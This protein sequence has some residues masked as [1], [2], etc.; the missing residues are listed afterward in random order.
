M[1]IRDSSLLRIIHR[2][3]NLMKS[4][5]KDT[6]LEDFLVDYMKQRAIAMSLIIIGESTKN[7]SEAFREG[8]AAEIPW[9][10][11]SGLRDIVAHTYDTLDM[12]AVFVTATDSIASFLSKIE[13]L[14]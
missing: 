14:I 6:T 13:K 5:M 2:E 4:A 7:L 3:A 12:E 10:R 1:T 11:I 8:T 9:R